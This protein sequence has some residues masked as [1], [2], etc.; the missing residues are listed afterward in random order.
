MKTTPHPQHPVRAHR[1]LSAKASQRTAQAGT[2]GPDVR[3]Q[4]VTVLAIRKVAQLMD[5][6]WDALVLSLGP[7]QLHLRRRKD[8]AARPCPLLWYESAL[9][10]RA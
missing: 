5:S 7:G 2:L 9:K 10:I 3:V 6:T 1:G 4:S 8:A